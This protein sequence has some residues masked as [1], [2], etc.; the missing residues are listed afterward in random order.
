MNRHT[1]GPWVAIGTGVYQADEVGNREIIFGGHNTR[2]ADSGHEQVANAELI[3]AAPE[4]LKMIKRFAK[5][6][7]IQDGCK[8]AFC[9]TIHAARRWLET[10]MEV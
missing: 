8:C 2:S 7:P 9:G 3:A 1:P 10:N 4:M 6:S 5:T